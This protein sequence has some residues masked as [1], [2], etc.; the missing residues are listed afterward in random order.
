MLA[1]ANDGLSND[2]EEEHEWVEI[3]EEGEEV[4]RLAIAPDVSKPSDVEVEEHRVTHMPYRKWCQECVM[5]RG[6]GERRGRHADR[7]HQVPR[8]GVDYFFI[9][10]GNIKKRQDLKFE[11]NPEGDSQLEEARSSGEITKGILVRCYESKVLFAHIVP[12]KGLDEDRYCVDLVVSDVAWL[13]HTK[14]L[15]KSD[16]ENP[17]VALIEQALRAIRCQVNVEQ[18]SREHS[19]EYD[20]QA[21]GGTEV[22]IRIVRGLFRTVKL[23]TERR[24][25]A[26]IPPNHPLTSW[27]LEHVALLHN[28]MAVGDDGKTAWARVRGR[29]FGQRLFGFGESVM[30][31]PAP[32]G[33]QHDSEGNMGSR[34]HPGIFLGYH[35][36]SNSYWIANKDG[37][38][39]KTRS[40]LRRPYSDRWDAEGLQNLTVTPW[41]LRIA[42]TPEKIELGEAVERYEKPSSEPTLNPRRIKITMKTLHDYGTSDGCRQCEH[43]R[44]FNEAKE[45]LAHSESCRKRIMEAMAQTAQGAARINRHEQ[46]FERVVAQQLE[47]D[48]RA[49]GMQQADHGSREVEMN[50]QEQHGIEEPQDQD[51]PGHLREVDSGAGGDEVPNRDDEDEDEHMGHVDQDHSWP[52]VKVA[53]LK[54]AIR[55]AERQHASQVFSSEEKACFQLLGMLGGDTRKYQREKKQAFRRIVSEVYSPPRVTQLL[56]TMGNRDLLPGLAFDITCNDPA[57]GKPWDFTLK[58]KRDRARALLR[59]QKPLFLIGSP[60]CTA[61]CSWQALNATRRNPK[62]VEKEMIEARVHLDFVISLY[63]EQ[64]AGGRFFLHEHPAY[65]SS[66]SEDAMRELE[67]TPGVRRI[68]SDQCMF[69]QEVTFGMFRGQPIKKPTGFLS[70]A[71]MLL[72]RLEMRCKGIG[73]QCSRRRGGAHRTCSGS[74]AREAARYP[75]RLCRAIVQGMLDEMRSRGILKR[76]EVGLHAMDDEDNEEHQPRGVE[77]GFSGKYRDDT[78]GQILKDS[79][80]V[81]ARR[82]EL[83]YFVSKGVWIKRPRAEARKNTGRGPISV[84]WVDVNKGDDVNPRYRSR[85]VARQLKAHDKSGESFFAPTPPLEALRTVLS[86]AAT[87]MDG[88]ETNRDPHSE[89]RT[90]ISILDISRAYFNAKLDEN[91]TTYVQLPQEDA[92]CQDMCAKLVRHMYGTRAAADGWQEEYSSFLVET[93]KFTQGISSPCIFRHSQRQIILTV[94]GD[95]FTSVGTKCDLDWFEAAMSEH[96]ELTSQPRIGP[97]MEDAKEAVILNRVIRW[98]E[99]GIEYEADPRQAEKLISEC[100]M[101]D[102]NPTATPGVRVSFDEAESDTPLPEKLHSAFRGAA[103]RANYLAMDRL[104]CQFAGK[105]ICRWMAKPTEGAWKALKRLCRYLVGLPRM[106]FHYKW[107]RVKVA[108]VY[109]DTDWAGCP[110]TR[111]STSGGCVLLGAHTIKSWSSTQ[112]SIALSSGEAEF[113]GVVRGAGI[114]LGYQSLLKDIGISVPVRVWTDS[115]AAVGI[116]SR[117]GLGKLRHIDTH[118]LWVQQAV[119]SGRIDLRKVAGHENPADLFT[120]HSLSRERL[121]NLTRLF[122]CEYR[123]G[124]AESAPQVRATAGTKVTMAEAYHIGRVPDVCTEDRAEGEQSRPRMPHREYE[125]S[126]LEQFFPSIKVGEEGSDIEEEEYDDHLLIEGMRRANDI[127]AQGGTYGRRRVMRGDDTRE[128]HVGSCTM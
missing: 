1:T 117:Q 121:M 109:T 32:K 63:V 12:C 47:R 22:G 97:G 99:N 118:T 8:V 128:P 85:L 37:D 111:K 113:N 70:N 31:K 110:R 2:V 93:L 104:D 69:G 10:A 38:A 59:K 41:N 77:Q 43:V 62:T 115:S 119:R 90:Q 36:S 122:D 103:A 80:V 25:G 68:T 82:K 123:G 13:G 19:H 79:L 9:T 48:D 124:R 54:D 53:D 21:N 102:S 51:G 18:V 11:M 58:A 75:L 125:S 4:R 49:R 106:I 116:C 46:R 94:H 112:S 44:A 71:P 89:E 74:V 7:A 95:D 66:W 127:V 3:A 61:W 76:G 40:L 78:T 52:T 83:E 27:I 6:I 34:M 101:A 16:N 35:R 24:I 17:L 39:I 105:E 126:S 86:L 88:W 107:Q 84:R 33:H 20:S 91:A 45:G 5:G 65:A 29:D 55:A 14:L 28:I 30:W 42:K 100:G 72:A 73:G 60:V 56:R 67:S 114:G 15:L 50:D 98:G 64:I 108:D 87:N 26:R 120:K 81:E 57:D 23:C 96:Y 92:D